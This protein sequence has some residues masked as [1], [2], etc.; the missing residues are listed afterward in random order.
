[1]CEIMF[2]NCWFQ[3]IS[4]NTPE[5]LE[6]CRYLG[7]QR[8]KNSFDR[9]VW[10]HTGFILKREG[11]LQWKIPRECYGYFLEKHTEPYL[12]WKVISSTKLL[13]FYLFWLVV[14]KKRQCIDSLQKKF[15]PKKLHYSNKPFPSH[16]TSLGAMWKC[17]PPTSSW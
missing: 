8:L 17:V 2:L 14:S 15:L 9:K 13:L 3:E 1:M 16:L 10:C 11:G 5:S 12:W 7:P 6:I 4:G